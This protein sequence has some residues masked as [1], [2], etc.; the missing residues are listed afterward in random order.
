MRRGLLLAVVM[1]IGAGAGS[2]ESQSAAFTKMPAAYLTPVNS[3]KHCPKGKFR[4]NGT[5]FPDRY[6]CRIG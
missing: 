6:L 5:C 2:A 3:G 1:V 4:C